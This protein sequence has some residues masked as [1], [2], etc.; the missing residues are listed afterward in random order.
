MDGGGRVVVGDDSGGEEE[1]KGEIWKAW[2]AGRPKR[3]GKWKGE[4]R[5]GHSDEERCDRKRE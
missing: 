5:V 4:R 2:N 3:D 1:E